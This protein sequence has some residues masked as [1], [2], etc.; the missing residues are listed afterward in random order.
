[1]KKVAS[2]INTATL[3][4]QK[5]KTILDSLSF[6][7]EKNERHVRF[8]LMNNIDQKLNGNIPSLQLLDLKSHIG[9]AQTNSTYE[10]YYSGISVYMTSLLENCSPIAICF[11]VLICFLL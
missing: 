9:L 6:T 3:L 4:G 1:M 2:N 10:E 7:I 11:H 5:R 8:E